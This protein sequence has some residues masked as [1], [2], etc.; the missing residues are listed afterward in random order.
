MWPHLLSIT[1]GD[2]NTSVEGK[3]LDCRDTGKPSLLR[4]A[5][6]QP[7]A[8]YKDFSTCEISRHILQLRLC[9]LNVLNEL[10][11]KSKRS[12]SSSMARHRARLI[13]HVPSVVFTDQ[14]TVPIWGQI[15]FMVGECEGK[16]SL[17]GPEYTSH[18]HQDS[19]V[20]QSDYTATWYF[21][22]QTDQLKD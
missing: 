20:K 9:G 16:M 2:V 22:V 17:V 7:A 4:H 15:N 14:F 10:S 1:A 13:Y 6:T 19:D 3:H 12:N 21:L 8:H 18:M 5:T 11:L